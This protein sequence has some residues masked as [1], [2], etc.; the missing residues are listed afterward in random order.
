MNMEEYKDTMKMYEL[1]FEDMVKCYIEDFEGYEDK[2]NLTDS[3][4]K[5][6]AK[7]MIYKNEY[8]W[9]VINDTIDAYIGCEL[10]NKECE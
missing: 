8:L 3:Q 6:I 9:E 2:P 4:I 10:I 1:V 5:D 7:K